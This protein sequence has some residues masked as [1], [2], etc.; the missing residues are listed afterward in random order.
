MLFACNSFL[1]LEVWLLFNFV[2]LWCSCVCNYVSVWICKWLACVQSSQDNIS[3]QFLSSA[4]LRKDLLFHA[5]TLT[6]YGSPELHIHT[7]TNGFMCFLGIW[8][9]LHICVILFTA[10]DLIALLC[11]FTLYFVN[12]NYLGDGLLHYEFCYL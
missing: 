6:L 11:M 8:T 10:Q 4:R 5:V 9:N 7:T 12:S 3:C 2:C 1:H